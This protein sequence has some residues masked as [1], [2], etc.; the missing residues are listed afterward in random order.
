MPVC[1]VIKSCEECPHRTAKGLFDKKPFCGRSKKEIPSVIG[2]KPIKVFNKFNLITTT[3]MQTV[4]IPKW[5]E[6]VKMRGIV[7]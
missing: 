1:I 7:K 4:L 6:L 5:C 3:R 2:T